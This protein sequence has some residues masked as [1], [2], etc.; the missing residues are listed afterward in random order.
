MV[1]LGIQ[2]LDFFFLLNNP[3]SDF[4]GYFHCGT[5]YRNHLNIRIDNDLLYL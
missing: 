3:I 1:I 2:Q 5:E 4:N